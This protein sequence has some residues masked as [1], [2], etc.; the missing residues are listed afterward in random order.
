MVWFQGICGLFDVWGFCVFTCALS[1]KD[2]VVLTALAWKLNQLNWTK[3]C[4]DGP[5]TN[6]FMLH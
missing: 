6:N 4:P 3:H 2:K 5:N 1:K